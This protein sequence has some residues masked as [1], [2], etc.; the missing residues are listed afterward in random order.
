MGGGVPVPRNFVCHHLGALSPASPSGVE[1][2]EAWREDLGTGSEQPR[3]P[4]AGPHVAA[5]D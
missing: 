1:R 2:I 5:D 4:P 3:P